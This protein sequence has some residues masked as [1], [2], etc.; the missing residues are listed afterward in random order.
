MTE[1]KRG[2]RHG[3]MASGL[4][5]EPK[6]TSGRTFVQEEFKNEQEIKRQIKLLELQ[7][8]QLE[9]AARTKEKTGSGIRYKSKRGWKTK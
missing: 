3:D 1:N 8:Q 9:D 7:L 4:A 6:I 2:A 5:K